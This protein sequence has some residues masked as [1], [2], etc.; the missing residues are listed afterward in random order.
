VTAAYEVI[1]RD[2]RLSDFF[3]G[4]DDTTVSLIS[5]G[6]TRGAPETLSPD[7]VQIDAN[8]AARMMCGHCSRRGMLFE[9]F[10]N[11]RRYAALGRCP[12]CHFVQQI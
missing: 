9:P 11:G 10:H 1:D 7:V 2:R 12:R 3:A 6:W 4:N 8:V 5:E